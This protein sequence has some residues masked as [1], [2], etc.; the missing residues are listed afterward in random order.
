MANT[1]KTFGL[2]GNQLKI[3]A[4][5]AMTIDHVGFLLLPQYPILRLIGRL[6]MP[7]FAWMIAEGCEHTRNRARYLFTVLGVG[8]V[9]QVVSWVAERSMTQCILITFSMSIL[10]I[11]VLDLANRK[12]G[13][14]TLCLLGITVI[15]VCYVCV[16]LPQ[17]IPGLRFSVD[18]SIYGVLLP[19][20]IYL[21]RTKAEKLLLSAGVLIMLA[22]GYGYFQWF[23]LLSLPLLALYNGR[24]GKMRLKYLFYF[25]YP[26]HLA[27]IYGIGILLTYLK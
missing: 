3:L 2:T 7:I 14:F 16:F 22:I 4:L 5:I 21:G 23:A 26:L 9:C 13:F 15:A 10:L 12:R 1:T 11:Y 17:D 20:A 6:A 25:Y 8:L 19:V 27:A 24:R 18:Y